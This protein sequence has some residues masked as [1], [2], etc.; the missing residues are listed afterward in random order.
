ML[1]VLKSCKKNFEPTSAEIANTDI[2]SQAVTR[3]N[4]VLIL[5]DDIGYEIPTVNGGQSYAT[6]NIDLMA[7]AGMRFTQCYASPLCSPSRF[8][9]LTGK[10][11]FRNYTTWGIMDQSQRTFANMLSD[12]GYDTYVAGKWQ[13]DGDDQSVRTFGFNQSYT[14]FEQFE[15]GTLDHDGDPNTNKAELTTCLSIN[16]FQS[17]KTCDALLL[18][19]EKQKI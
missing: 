1:T 6:P 16:D 15:D 14:I 17:K 5:G 2:L 8:M 10:Y 3:P 9:F 4:I 12:A 13:V 18:L 11:N 19:K 7:R